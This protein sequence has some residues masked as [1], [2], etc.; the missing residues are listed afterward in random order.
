MQRARPALLPRGSISL[1]GVYSL[2]LSCSAPQI[3]GKGLLEL[4]GVEVGN[5]IDIG[6]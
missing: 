6:F 2:A 4:F 5:G 1:S 3:A